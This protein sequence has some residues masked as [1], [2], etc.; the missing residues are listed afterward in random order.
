MFL[1]KVR[2]AEDRLEA[3]RK[4]HKARR[5][6]SGVDSSFAEWVRHALDQAAERDGFKPP[7][8]FE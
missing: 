7:N 3:Y 5:R 8:P 1:Q 4:A 2:V 6:K